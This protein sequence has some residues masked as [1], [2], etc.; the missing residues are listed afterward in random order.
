LIPHIVPLPP[1]GTTTGTEKKISTLPHSVLLEGLTVQY[2]EKLRLLK[3]K[4]LCRLLGGDGPT[5]LKFRA[6]QRHFCMLLYAYDYL[7]L[8]HPNLSRPQHPIAMYH[9]HLST[10]ENFHVML[11]YVMSRPMSRMRLLAK[12]YPFL[13]FYSYLSYRSHSTT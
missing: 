9:V 6:V 12:V 4:K 11:H 13:F 10:F 2:E 3:L 5:T 8:I 1:N 7:Q